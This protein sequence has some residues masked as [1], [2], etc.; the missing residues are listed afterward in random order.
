MTTIKH[1]NY[2]I[3]GLYASEKEVACVVH[4]YTD[5]VDVKTSPAPTSPTT[6][7]TTHT[8]PPTPL[9]E[10]QVI[11]PYKPLRFTGFDCLPRTEFRKRY[12]YRI[13]GTIIEPGAPKATRVVPGLYTR[14]TNPI[15]VTAHEVTPEIRYKPVDYTRDVPFD[16]GG[17][18]LSVD[19]FLQ[20]FPYRL[21]HIRVGG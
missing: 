12:P 13:D 16:W 10:F 17:Y 2:G 14:R 3:H 5:V 15:I 18:R 9:L 11:L 7:S 4:V 8:T 21:T 1:S 6:P 19:E 20:Q